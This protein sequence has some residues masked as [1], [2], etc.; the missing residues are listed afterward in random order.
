M[1]EE[2]KT[3]RERI[4][5]L[6]GQVTELTNTVLSVAEEFNKMEKKHKE[7]TT[8]FN[9]FTI[10]VLKNSDKAFSNKVF[11]EYQKKI[12]NKS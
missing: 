11:A 8:K 7:L 3:P 1:S 5:W 2:T 10:A 4:E 12:F 9:S 6:E